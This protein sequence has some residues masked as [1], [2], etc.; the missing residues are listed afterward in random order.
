MTS[1]ERIQNQKGLWLFVMPVSGISFAKDTV[2]EIV[3]DKITF[4]SALR[5]PRVR[6]RLGFPITLKELSKKRHI[7]EFFNDYK[8]Y[9]VSLMGG[10]GAKREEEFLQSVEDELSIISASQL[11]YGRR[12][13]HSFLS[14]SVDRKLGFSRVFMLNTLNDDSV[15]SHNNLGAKRH[16]LIINNKWVKD[17]RGSFFYYLIDILNGRMGTT[18]NWTRDIRNAAILAGQSQSC[19]KLTHAF[20]L[21]MIAIETLLTSQG[22]SYS[23]VLPKRVEAFIGWTTAW[24][25]GDFENRIQGAYKKRCA[26]VHAGKFDGLT[27][28]DLVFSDDIL[29]NVFFNI[30]K[31]IDI[32]RS[33]E[34]L[35]LFSKKV[36]AEHL[37]GIDTKVR[38]KNIA[39]IQP[40]YN[41][42]D[43]QQI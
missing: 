11:G 24:A 27:V 33:K 25:I 13:N 36:E 32:F 15:I 21:N 34:D 19:D 6:A 23:S 41:D 42:K 26:F 1:P 29:F 37:L 22:D 31:N 20:L 3:I 30:V 38:P 40:V 14:S 16:D 17:Q 12:R 7:G 4:V 18:D 39:F 35:I 8:V 28:R 5:L 9:A 43:Y 2:N 10:E